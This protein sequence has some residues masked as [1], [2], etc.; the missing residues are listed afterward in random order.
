MA[1]DWYYSRNAQQLGPVSSSKLKDLAAT[2][3]LQPTDLIWRDGMSKWM[4]A[5]TIKGLFPESVPPPIPPQR[6]VQQPIQQQVQFQQ[7]A[8]VQQPMISGF[9]KCTT[10]VEWIRF[11]FS[12][13]W[14]VYGMPMTCRIPLATGNS[15]ANAIDTIT[16]LFLSRG[17]LKRGALATLGTSGNTLKCPGAIFAIRDVR[18]KGKGNRVDVV[19]FRND[20]FSILHDAGLLQD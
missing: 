11:L 13:A 6:A 14:V 18:I 17:F 7:H 10:S 9:G 19:G 8:P 3:E 4:P 2:G 12:W 15:T 1:T 20:I 5:N 16:G